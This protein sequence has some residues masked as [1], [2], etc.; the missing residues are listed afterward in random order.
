MAL[1]ICLAAKTLDIPEAGGTFWF[2]LNWAL[3][4]RALG[5]DV[6]WLEAAEPSTPS[7]QVV[8]SVASLKSRLERYG[9]AHCVAL[10]S[11]TSESLR[12]EATVGC[13]DQDAACASDLLLNLAYGIPAQ[14]VE[15]FRR[16][17][18]VD[19]DPGLTQIWISNGEM[20]VAPHDVYF[21][22][23]ETVGQ[24]GAL[25]PDCG[26]TWHYT[27]PAVF[28]PAWPPTPATAAAPY[29][30]VTSWWE[31][32]VEFRGESYANGKR[33]G[34]VPFL[35]LPRRAP[36]AIELAISGAGPDLA[37]LVDSGWRVCDADTVAGTPWDYQRYIQASRGEFSCAKPSCVRLQNAWVSDRTLCYL[38]GGKPAIVQH[39]GSSRFLPDAAGLF[40]FRNQ[41]EAVRHLETATADYGVHS[42][43]ARAL[44]EEY[45]DAQ[46]IV[47]GVLEQ[48]L[49]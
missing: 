32:W 47:A 7:A 41:D 40:R 5:C 46:K 16:S 34:F 15:R 11:W 43:L 21:T 49:S 2:Y 37:M 22:I 3:G 39:T 8:M 19:I 9:L 12:S 4:L 18:L 6:I 33:D 29:T 36:V 30:T 10:C 14:M 27:P 20:T 13:I 31:E 28:L 1:T 24:P 44:A 17:A 26:L 48:A 45:F 35:D 23:G 25:F 42:K 38:A